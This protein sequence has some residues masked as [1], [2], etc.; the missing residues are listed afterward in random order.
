MAQMVESSR[1]QTTDLRE[2]QQIPEDPP[3]T[4]TQDSA[5][6]LLVNLLLEEPDAVI[7][8]VRVCGGGGG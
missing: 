8:L 1:R 5:P 7:R 2:A 3:V 4:E 6:P